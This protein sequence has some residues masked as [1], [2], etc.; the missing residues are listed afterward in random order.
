MKRTKKIF[1]CIMSSQN[2]GRRWILKICTFNVNSINARKDLIVQWVEQRN[3]DIDVLCFQELK[4]E[5]EHFPYQDFERLGY[6]SIV[7][8]QK[9]YNGVAICSKL[10]MKRILE[11]ETDQYWDPQKR[12]IAARIKAINLINIYAPHGDVR[13]TEK[14]DYKRDWYQKLV[15]FLDT[16]FSA[17]KALIMVGDFNVAR[18]DQ[19]VWSPEIL[20][21]S[22]GTMPEERKSFQELLAWGFIDSFRSLYPEKKQF[23]WWDYIGGAIWRD[24]GMRIDYVL[25][26]ESLM[27]RAQNIEVDLWPRKR[28]KPTPSDHAPLIV[29]LSD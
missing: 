6:S 12:I 13:G 26:T 27:K 24:Q 5:Q 29:T 2:P 17:D 11:K 9:A 3:K 21:D 8:G 7:N 4:S 20:K 18:D 22:I 23:T 10:P 1:L 28:R 16:H 19:D 15:S 25:C 14:F